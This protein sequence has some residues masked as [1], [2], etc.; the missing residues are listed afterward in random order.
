MGF[1]TELSTVLSVL[2]ETKEHCTILEYNNG[3]I[4]LV[5]CHRMRPRINHIDIKYH[6]FRSKVKER[7]VTVK[8]IDNKM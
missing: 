5:K 8:S 2:I 3:C 6:H 4:E 1:I 7:L